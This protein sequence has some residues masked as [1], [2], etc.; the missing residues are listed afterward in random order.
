[1]KMQEV[2]LGDVDMGRL[3]P[4][5]EDAARLVV[6]HP[7]GFHIAQFS[8]SLAIGYNRAGRIMDLVGVKRGLWDRRKVV[9][10]VRCSV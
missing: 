4:L 3:D 6:I 7:A 8:V 2:I 10:R 1:M 9:R 5:F